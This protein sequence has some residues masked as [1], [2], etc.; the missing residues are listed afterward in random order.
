MEKL[1]CMNHVLKNFTIKLEDWKKEFKIGKIVD[2]K[3]R[4]HYR[5][6]ISKIVRECCDDEK[7]FS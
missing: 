3:W 1:D 6:L 2:E 5:G 7:N 4:L